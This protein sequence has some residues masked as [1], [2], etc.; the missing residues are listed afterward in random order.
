MFSGRIVSL[1]PSRNPTEIVLE[2]S[3]PSDPNDPK[4]VLRAKLLLATPLPGTMPVGSEIEFKGVM[5]A[6]QL[7]LLQVSF[8]IDPNSNGKIEGWTGN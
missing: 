4:A 8:E 6:F 3:D 1:T 2:M 5:R 7:D